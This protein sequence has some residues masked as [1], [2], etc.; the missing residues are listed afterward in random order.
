MSGSATLGPS[1]GAADMRR[2]LYT[3]GWVMLALAAPLLLLGYL[4][5]PPGGLMF[6]LPYLF[7]IPGVPLALVGALLVLICRGSRQT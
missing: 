5:W 6:A 7:L 3:L 4:T 1:K 2:S